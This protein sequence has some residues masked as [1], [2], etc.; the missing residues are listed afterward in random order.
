MCNLYILNI[1]YI[2]T[3]ILNAVYTC[4]GVKELMQDDA[5]Y[6]RSVPSHSILRQF[7]MLIISMLHTAVYNCRSFDGDKNNELSKS[8]II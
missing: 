1:E 8:V 5:R 4:S 3:Q 2:C 7:Q 6:K